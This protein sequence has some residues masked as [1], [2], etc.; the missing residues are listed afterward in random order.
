MGGMYKE[1]VEK[2]MCHKKEQTLILTTESIQGPTGNS[3]QYCSILFPYR[4]PYPYIKVIHKPGGSITFVTLF[5]YCLYIFIPLQINIMAVRFWRGLTLAA[6]IT[7][8]LPANAAPNATSTSSVPH[9]DAAN[10]RAQ[11]IKE[12]FLHAYN[13]YLEYAEGHDELL[14]VTNA[15]S[16]SRYVTKPAE[17]T[18]IMFIKPWNN[19]VLNY[20]FNVTQKRMGR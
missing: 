7:L 2:I 10:E 20:I 11:A 9:C 17:Y 18:F 4:K 16:D 3:P 8:L 1:R 5:F 6:C 19:L 13:G 14:P 15:P 12:A